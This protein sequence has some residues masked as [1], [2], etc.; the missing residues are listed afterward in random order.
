[1]NDWGPTSTICLKRSVFMDRVGM[2]YHD[3]REDEHNYFF[4]L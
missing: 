1:M 2:N 3:F 4:R